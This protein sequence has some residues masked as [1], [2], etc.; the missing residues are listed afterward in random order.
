MGLAFTPT[1]TELCFQT[2]HIHTNSSIDPALSGGMFIAE[3]GR[4]RLPA[5]MQVGQAKMQKSLRLLSFPL[6]PL[7]TMA[8]QPN[9]LLK[10][11]RHHFADKLLNSQS[12]GFSSSHLRMWE[13]NHKASWVTKNW[14]FQLAMLEKT[15]ESPLDRKEIKP[16]N[17]KGNQP[18]MF[19]GR[20]DSEVAPILWPP[21]IKSWLIGKDPDDGRH[22]IKRRRR[23]PEDEMVR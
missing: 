15:L 6:T 13:L 11:Q 4:L 21:D 8:L 16:L 9:S 23:G 7:E 17:P 18:W 19:I 12:Y 5:K 1:S 10:E 3:M 2:F 20:T 14:C 22:W